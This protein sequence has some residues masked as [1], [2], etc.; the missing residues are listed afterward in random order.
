MSTREFTNTSPFT[1]GLFC[2]V[3]LF[4]FR[5]RYPINIDS[6]TSFEK[7]FL[8]IDGDQFELLL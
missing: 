5:P 1:V 8:S 3:N 7:L 4:G 6:L 2:S